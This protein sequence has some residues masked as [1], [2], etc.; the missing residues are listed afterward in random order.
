MLAAPA[1]V[2][3]P[4]EG[5]DTIEPLVGDESFMLLEGEEHSVGRKVVLPPF[6]ATA[7]ARASLSW[8]GAAWPARGRHVA[9]GRA[10]R[11][12]IRRLRVLTL[13]DAPAQRSLAPRGT[14]GEDER[15]PSCATA[16]SRCSPI[17]ASAVLPE[18]LLRRGPGR[19]TWAR[20]LHASSGASTSCI[21]SIIERAQRKAA[22]A[23]ADLLDRLL[24]ARNPDGSAILVPQVRDDLMSIVLAGHETTASELAWAFQL[25]AHNPR[26]QERLIEELDAGGGEEYLTATVKEVLRHRPV[27]LFAIPRAVKRP[28]EIGGWHLPAARRTCS[29]ASICS[30]TTRRSIPEPE[31][32]RPERFLGARAGTDVAAVGRRAQALSGPASGDARDRD[33]AAHGA[34]EH[35]GP[36]PRSERSSVR[37]GAA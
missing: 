6:R 7:V 13:R 1:D 19:G 28:I 8:P 10:L 25:L 31:E 24:D 37:A 5:A 2:L 33:G 22:S 35:D 34:R 12:R 17:T 21:Y 18:P 27:F 16:C 30:T 3:H 29:R 20:F 4:G 23:Q 9:A 26:V 14:R 32:F 36:A 15:L 11:A